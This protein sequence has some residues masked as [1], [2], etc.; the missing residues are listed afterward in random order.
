[1]I[2]SEAHCAVT[3]EVVDTINTGS[4]ITTCMVNTVVNVC[5][6]K[7]EEKFLNIH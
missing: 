5:V 2:S 1:M 4:I 3:R 7:I 6:R